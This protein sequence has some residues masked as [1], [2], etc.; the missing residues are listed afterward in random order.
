[1]RTGDE[2]EVAFDAV[3]GRIFKGKVARVI[4]AIATGQFQA[5]GALQ[6]MG[7]RPPGG[8]AVAII[9]IDDDTS[10]Y[11]LPG[12][13]A[14]QVAVYTEYAHHFAIIRRILLRMRSWQ[15]FVFFE[16]HG[17]PGNQGGGQG[18]ERTK[19]VLDR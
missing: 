2:A 9:H 14:A 7:E 10:L 12:G 18:H 17:S 11:Q 1:V 3:P 16:D 8:R 13:A 6:V 4:D 19:P 15:N 5:A